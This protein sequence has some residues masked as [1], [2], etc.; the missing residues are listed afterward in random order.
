R[1]NN[2]RRRP[3]RRCP[4]PAPV[5][6]PGAHG[7]AWGRRLS[8]LSNPLE[9]QGVHPEPVIGRGYRI[10]AA[11]GMASRAHRMAAAADYAPLDWGHIAA[12]LRRERENTPD[13]RWVENNYLK[14]INRPLPSPATLPPGRRS[15]SASRRVATGSPS[16]PSARPAD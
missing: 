8:T 4:G 10:A 5:R 6:R 3:G 11:Q 15:A 16:P 9:K 13:L 2:T 7:A 14:K 1:S 12:N